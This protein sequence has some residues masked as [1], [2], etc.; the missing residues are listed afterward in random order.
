MSAFKGI[1]INQVEDDIRRF[2]HEG[3][4]A[5]CIWCLQIY[6]TLAEIRSSGAGTNSAVDLENTVLLL[7]K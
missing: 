4:F 2:N 5:D 6:R 7:R 3:D 1:N